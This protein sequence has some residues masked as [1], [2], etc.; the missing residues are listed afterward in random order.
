MVAGIVLVAF[1]MKTTIAHVGDPLD[2]V[3]AAA[4]A[5]GAALYLL[6]HVAFRLRNLR[7]AQPAATGRRPSCCS[8]VIPLAL[9]VPAVVTAAV[10]A[11]L[12]SGL[13]AYE[14]HHFADARDRIRHHTGEQP[15]M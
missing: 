12:Y 15:V 10:V 2:I 6:A 14:A 8:A 4:L 1:G 3:P 9:V 5:G 11:A 7:H 13:I